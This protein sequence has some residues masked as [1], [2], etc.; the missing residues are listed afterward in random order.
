MPSTTSKQARRWCFTINNFTPQDVDRL[1]GLQGNDGVRY[2]VCGAEVGASGTPHLQ[3]Y[4]ELRTPRRLNGVKDLLGNNGVHLETARGTAVQASE[5]CKKDGDVLVEFG[6]LGGSQGSRN[7]LAQVEELVRAGADAGT[8][9]ANCFGPFIKY[10]RGI[11][12]AISALA[13]P[14]D[15][16]TQVVWFFGPTGSGKTRRAHAESQAL[17]GGSVSWIADS[18]LTWFDG[19]R[20]NSKGVVLDDFDGRAPLALLLRIFDRYP[21]RVPIKGNFLEW[22]PRIVWVTSNMHPEDLYGDRGEHFRA[23]LRRIDEIT[24]IE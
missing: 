18:T 14:R 24:K 17:C 12:R 2:L 7:D 9:A 4:L 19:Y 15:W 16:R 5:Y 3:G 13:V 6:T 8:I 20:T 22:N 11:E 10:H 23:L 1:A 21:M